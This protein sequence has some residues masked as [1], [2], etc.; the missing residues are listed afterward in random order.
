MSAEQLT[1]VKVLFHVPFD[2][3]QRANGGKTVFFKTKEYLE[4]AGVQVD[5]FDPWKTQ[6]NT[7][8]LIHCFTMQSTDMWDFAKAS[9]LRL[10]VTP[11]S[12]YGVYVTLRSRVKRWIKRQ[13]RSRI[14]CPLHE[15]WWEECFS[16]PD[17][18]FP[19]SEEQAR[20]LRTA[21][22]VQAGRC[23]AVPHGVDDR[24]AD[25]DA[26]PFL[27]KYE[28]KD[29]VLS[30]GRFEPRKNQLSLVRALKGTGLQMVFIGSPHSPR[31]NSYFQQCV[32]EAGRSARFITDIDHDSPML[33]SAY[34][35]ARVFVLPSLLEYPGL[36]ALEAGMAGCNVAV[37]EVGVARDYLGSHA[38]YL[39]PY[40][41]R[42][43]RETV[44]DCYG[45]DPTRNSALQ[46]HVKK[47]FRW[48]KVILGNIEG[49]SR[50]LG[51]G[52]EGN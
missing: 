38:R 34:A 49:Y 5:L 17:M 25:A 52:S 44:L 3:L 10:A 30:V 32:D 1:V 37:T 36:V 7:Y 22:S 15:Y 11:I 47:H 33:E 46:D 8:D 6:L 16:W 19:Q 4:R 14:H 35:A 39:D 51:R 24:F 9:G 28:V 42:S 12:W 27:K 50:I 23:L 18:F 21:F 41:L 29:F 31:F 20:Q 13:F 45:I 43:I 26:T 48:E 2:V 40:S